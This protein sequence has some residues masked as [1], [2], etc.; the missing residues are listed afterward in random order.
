MTY[1]ARDFRFFI[2]NEANWIPISGIQEWSLNVETET[3]DVT[4]VGSDGW[5]SELPVMT[6]LTVECSGFVVI[7]GT[8]RDAGQQLVQIAALNRRTANFRI[9]TT[10]QNTGNPIGRI[11]GTVFF[12]LPRGSG[13]ATNETDAFEFVAHFVGSPALSGIFQIAS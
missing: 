9:D 2:Q 6:K 10:A 1:L 3:A 5:K 13:G 7:S 8:S 11:E 4:V 12:E